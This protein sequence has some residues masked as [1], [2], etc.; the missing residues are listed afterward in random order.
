MLFGALFDRALDNLSG[1]TLE[2]LK[3]MIV[4]RAITIL[5]ERMKKPNTLSSYQATCDPFKARFGNREAS[6]VLPGEIKVYLLLMPV[7]D[8][9][10][11][12]RF[13]HLKTMFN[14][15]IQ[16]LR[17][18]RMPVSW[19]NPCIALSKDFKGKKH[20]PAPLSDTIHADM[21]KVEQSLK[22][23]HRLIYSLGVIA[24]LRVS[25]ILKLRPVDIM[26]QND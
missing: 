22:S 20:A 14:V 21:S 2:V 23:K 6:E 10:R 17:E 8:S 18:A 9:T 24:R 7:S 16:E 26:R 19:E 15:A 13:T 1:K 12:L 4:S 5:Y 11:K 3:I 25:E